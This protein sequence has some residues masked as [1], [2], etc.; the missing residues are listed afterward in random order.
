MVNSGVRH[1]KK[2]GN[3]NWISWD[4]LDQRSHGNLSKFT[5]SENLNLR[6]YRETQSQNKKARLIR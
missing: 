5:L 1:N 6:E 2:V 3:T 4:E